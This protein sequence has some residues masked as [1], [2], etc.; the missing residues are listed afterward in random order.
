MKLPFRLIF[1]SRFYRLSVLAVILPLA[2]ISDVA[3]QTNKSEPDPL[4][5]DYDRAMIRLELARNTAVTLCFLLEKGYGNKPDK[6]KMSTKRMVLALT[7]KRNVES[8]KPMSYEESRAAYVWTLTPKGDLV[9]SEFQKLL[10]Q[11]GDC[12]GRIPNGALMEFVDNMLPCMLEDPI[13]IYFHRQRGKV[14]SL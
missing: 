12:Q 7:D 11:A 10:I 2:F 9:T 8:D 14:C 1:L 6:I 4:Q 3:A 5:E 13:N